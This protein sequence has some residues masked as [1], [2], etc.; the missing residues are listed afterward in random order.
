MIYQALGL[1]LSG[2]S[3]F[4]VGPYDSWLQPARSGF[5]PL[6]SLCRAKMQSSLTVITVISLACGALAQ[7]D[8]Y[9]AAGE[10]AG[11][12]IVPCG[13]SNTIS[14]CCQIGD[15]CL[16][17]LCLGDCHICPPT[18][19]LIVTALAGTQLTMLHTCMA[20]LTRLILTHHARGNVVLTMVNC[21]SAD[22]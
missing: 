14:S 22:P 16:R 11:S 20:A 18:H 21:S 5:P 15:L 4:I 12:A 17:Y 9:Y 8:C 1:S 19:V 13:S 6:P 3:L 10:R 2:R 7:N